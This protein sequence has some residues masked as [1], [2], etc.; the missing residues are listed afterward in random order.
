MSG[1]AEESQMCAM[2]RTSCCWGTQFQSACDCRAG[3]TE[4]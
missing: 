1:A 4:E 2:G 3:R